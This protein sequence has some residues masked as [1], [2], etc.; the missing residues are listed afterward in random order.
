MKQSLLFPGQN[1][2]SLEGTRKKI[3]EAFKP[4]RLAGVLVTVNSP[5]GS[6]VQSDLMTSFLQLQA[7]KTKVPVTVFVEDLAASGGYWLAC[8]GDNIFASPS[9]ILG[10]LGVVYSGLGLTELISK[11]G[12][13]R[14]LI[15]AGKSKALMDPL[16]PTKEEDVAVISKMC[17]DIHQIFIH[18]VKTNRGSRL[19]GSD[20]EL[21]NGAIWTAGDALKHGLID[22]IDN[23]ESYIHRNFGEEVRVNRMRSKFEEIF[24]TFGAHSLLSKPSISEL[25]DGDSHKIRI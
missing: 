14:R 2:L 19:V 21:F 13:E 20:E 12:V 10:S 11:I 6:P 25:V 7:R 8:A 15:T 9:S 18:H 22:G 4:E 3:E 24:E 23:V 5:G 17:A 16:S 1:C